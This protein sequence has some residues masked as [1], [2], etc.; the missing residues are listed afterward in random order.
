[1]TISFRELSTKFLTWS[2]LHQAPLSTAFYE[3]Y[4]VIFLDYLGDKANEPAEVMKPYQLDEWTDSR[5]TWGD[6][7]KRGAII[8]VNRVFNWGVRGG[9]IAINPIKTAFKPPSQRRKAYF[10][11]DDFQEA[12]SFLKPT[13]PFYDLLQFFWQTG[14]RPKEA[15]DIE[16]RHVNLAAGYVLFPKEESKGKR[17]QRRILMNEIALEIIKRW[18]DKNPD[19]KVFRNK[20]GDAWTKFSICN[21]MWHLQHKTGKKLTAYGLRHGFATRKLKAKH[22]HLEIAEVLG[23]SDGSMLAKVYSH[24]DDD[25]QHLRTVLVD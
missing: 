5:S 17:K 11:P 10:K 8:S 18:M 19:G 13:D 16:H 12:I 7:Y 20:R 22:G 14:C 25:E 4:I 3:N 23:H 9:Y 21:R 15:R 2:R 24:V 1:M 6:N